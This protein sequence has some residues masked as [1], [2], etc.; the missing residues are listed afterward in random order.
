[1]AA[2]DETETGAGTVWSAELNRRRF[3][4]GAV[5]G[6]GLVAT[7]LPLARLAAAEV[8]V[9]LSAAALRPDARVRDL[10][11]A[12]TLDEKVGLLHQFSVAVIRLGI[13][14]FRTG[15]ECLHG[16]SW[17]GHATVFPQNTGLAMTW[18]P[19]L[20]SK[21][22]NVIG[23]ETRAYNS[24]DAR[25]N[26]IDLWG[27]VVDLARDPR[28][29]RASESMGE[30][31]TLAAIMSTAMARGMKGND[32]FYY[33]SIPTLKHVAAYGQEASRTSYSANATPRNLHEYYLRVFRKG[34][35]SGAA[36]GMMT[37]YNLVNGKPTMV[38]PEMM[39]TVYEDWVAGGYGNCAYFNVT[40]AGSPG[41]LTGSN[42]YYPNNSVGQAAAMADSIKNGVA[43]MTPGDT[44]TPSTR[45]PIYEALARGMLTGADIDK[46]V[47][48]I[49]MVRLHAGDL[50]TEP[51]NPYKRLNKRNALTT[52]AHNAVAAQAA[53]EQVVLLKNTDHVLPLDKSLSRLALVG[54]LADENSTDFYAGTYP[55]TT[56]I[57][58]EVA[59][60]LKGGANSLA[61]TRGLNVIG[62]RVVNGTGTPDG[63][64]LTAGGTAD[65]S[66]TGSAT[67]AEDPLAQFYDYDYGYNNHLLRSVAHD[68]YLAAR[69]AGNTVMADADPPGYQSPHRSSQQWTTDQNLGI[70]SRSGTTVSLRFA[71][72]T[73]IVSP[74]ANPNV[75]VD[76]S[77]PYA[78]R[79][80]GSASSPNRQFQLVTVKD[81][82]ADAVAKASSAP[83]A[84]VVV[85]D[86]PH[87]TSR[88]TQDRLTT[89]PD[90]K[91]PP[92][93][94]QLVDAVAA[95][96]PNTVV[97]VVGS[98]PFDLRAIAANPNVK[99]IV[100][101]SHAGQELGSAVADVLFGDH[102]PAG[103]LN[104]T[105]YPGLDALPTISDYDII[106]GKRTY[107]Y[108]DGDVLYP[109]GYGLTYT[110]FRY[111]NLTVN[112]ASARNTRDPDVAVG[113]TVTNTGAV[114]SDDVVQVYASY[115]HSAE[116]RVE[117]PKKQLIGF[118]RVHLAPGRS[119]RVTI[120]AKLSDLAIWD[121]S[122][123]RFFVEPGRYTISA[124]RSSSD[125]D[126]LVSRTL[127]VTGDPIPARDLTRVTP[128]C[129]FDDHSFTSRT[130][131]GLQADVVPTSVSEDNTYGIL[132]RTAGAWVKYA[133][134]SF[135]RR[136]T[137][138]TVRASNPNPSASNVAVW[139]GGPS[140]DQG[141][142]RIGTITVAP[143]GNAQTFVN[144][145]AGLTRPSGR[146]ADLYL[147]FPDAGVSVKWLRLGAVA[148]ATSAD[149]SIT[150]NLFGSSAATSL[151]RARVRVPATI[152]QQSA[153][154]LLEAQ[155][156]GTGVVTGPPTWAVTAPDGGPTT[157]A[158]INSSGQLTATGAGDGT[159]RVT[160]TY[161]TSNGTAAAGLPVTL[162]N[163]AVPAGTEPEAII[164]RSGH[165]SRPRDISWGPNQFSRFG[166][167][168]QHRGSLVLSAVTYPFPSEARPVT[169]EL[170][171]EKGRPTAL[172]E[173][174]A[175]A[176]GFI[177]GQTSGNHN[178]AWNCTIRA[179]GAGDGHVH[180]KATTGN[181]LS[182]TTRVV[183]QGQTNKNAFAVRHEAQLF[184][185]SGNI[186]G[187]PSNL[188][189]DNV[190]GDD[191]GLQLNRIRNGDWAAYHKIDFRDVTRA[192]LTINYV[193]V[194]TEPALI[195]IKADDPVNG[196]VLGSV[197]V[198]GDHDLNSVADHRNP[199]YHW[200]RTTVPIT[201]LPGVHDLYFVF[202]ISPAI[203]DTDISNT[204]GAVA[205]WLDLG[206][207]W[208][209]IGC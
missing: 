59:A 24:V 116:S 80:D 71:K 8:P 64:F 87:L 142:T 21:V 131:T 180:L 102:A 198:T 42:G 121:V 82:I 164:I 65:A 68:R 127:T 155:L 88:E 194:S 190:H 85:G 209:R 126:Q 133:D 63:K 37:S 177:E 153:S 22:G 129:D 34:I 151:G 145:G 101:T 157:L 182:C 159:V 7:Q 20:M 89:L 75:Q 113:L 114:A 23:Q 93:Q 208:F 186:S 14:Q 90:I 158:T 28:S 58:D 199:L 150:S 5:V 156:R 117:H 44:D 46:A 184:D 1:M 9:Q 43:V 148:P 144:A 70:V 13:P 61:F 84:V 179:T 11:A 92:H 169:F 135:G 4:G 54:P 166:A 168:D 74:T 205:G 192:S 50:D 189:A 107:E 15:T 122:R 147:V 191:V 25:F 109:F 91:L 18:N 130:S 132:A 53:R 165:D 187:A 175:S 99:A 45:R 108:Y 81:G 33:Q 19:A 55:Y 115:R 35:E 200:R 203:P 69:G 139:S 60:K 26:G 207:N 12:L 66:L 149:V 104:Q 73:G 16:L 138:I 95:A 76:T 112:P 141:G 204:Y 181:G 27:P 3:L 94:Q 202:G 162:K 171:D 40:D 206:I 161:A 62:L 183:I 86:Q 140:A 38:F 78:V 47:H 178:R 51:A 97:V 56:Y 170:T 197:T 136:S 195:T 105:W 128:A 67:S 160:A 6:A 32:P 49:L 17:L 39:S 185:A 110:S 146:T 188:R 172:A 123:S 134:V 10:I 176:A 41:N 174:T 2:H 119:R 106:K 120:S 143:T 154:L 98:Y 48:G 52:P 124:G 167:I 193:K 30:D 72:S 196:A 77:A 96:N 173:I 152:E 29:G 36:N 57:K 111:S 83:V 137:G 118:Q 163:Q 31:V 201:A 79:H 100:Y 125:A 103:R